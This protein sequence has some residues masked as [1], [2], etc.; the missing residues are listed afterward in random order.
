MVYIAGF[1]TDPLILY[2]IHINFTILCVPILSRSLKTK[3]SQPAFNQAIAILFS[4]FCRGEM[5]RTSD[6]HVPNVAR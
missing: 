4:K 3:K 1:S 5:T 6:L 2:A